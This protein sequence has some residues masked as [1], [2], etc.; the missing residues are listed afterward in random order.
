[1][2]TSFDPIDLAAVSQIKGELLTS[3][4]AS[5]QPQSSPTVAIAIAAAAKKT[6]P[7]TTGQQKK[8]KGSPF[9]K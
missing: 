3:M 6:S 9:F 5:K 4:H 7:P 1:M 2:K 8:R